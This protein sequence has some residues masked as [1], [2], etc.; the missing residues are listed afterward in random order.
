MEF[1]QKFLGQ[2]KVQSLVDL[3]CGDWQF[4]QH[5]NLAGFSYLGIDAS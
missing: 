4:S 2:N 3:G 5:H 1:L